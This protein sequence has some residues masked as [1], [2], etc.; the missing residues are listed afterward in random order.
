[1]FNLGTNTHQI[2]G[3]LL[4]FRGLRLFHS[5]FQKTRAKEELFSTRN[6][7]LESGITSKKTGI[8]SKFSDDIPEGWAE[9]RWA[10]GSNEFARICSL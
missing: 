5:S 7:I 6:T 1:M 3:F 9:G 4:V 2:H 8:T 10:F